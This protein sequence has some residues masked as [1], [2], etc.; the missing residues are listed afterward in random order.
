MGPHEAVRVT[1]A[2]IIRN[3]RL[4]AAR[5]GRKDAHALRWELP[6]GKQEEG[7]SLEECLER[8]LREELD[9]DAEV[10]ALLCRSRAEQAGSTIELFAFEIDRFQGRVRPRE[11]EEI[12]WIAPSEFQALDFLEADRPLLAEI[13]R[14]WEDLKDA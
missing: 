9:V 5:R 11:H 14:R 13:A 4:L 2:V 7:E 10:G 8:E 1:A 12:R 3:G 6:G